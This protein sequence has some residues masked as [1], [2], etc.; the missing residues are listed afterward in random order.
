MIK[1]KKIFL[2]S[3]VA[4]CVAMPAFA[5][6]SHTGTFPSGGL[7][8]ADYTYTNAA[9]STNMDGVYE[10]TVNANAQYTT[11][12]YTVTA[13]HYLPADSEDPNTPC[14]AGNFCPGL[15]N[16]VQYSAT[17]N[18]GLETCPSGYGNSAEGA[19]ANTDCYRTCAIANNGTTF[20][21]IA[22][23]TAVS[24]NDYYNTTATDTCEPTACEN[25]WHVKPGTPDLT[26][27]IGVTE[28]GTGY[29]LNN[30]TGDDY[31]TN[32]MSNTIIANDPMAFAV[33]YGNGKGVIKG[34]GRCSKTGVTT[35]WYY[36]Q[37]YTFAADHFVNNLTNETDP[38]TGGQYCYCQL[39]SYTA[40]GSN[41]SIALSAPWVFRD[42]NDDA[43]DCVIDCAHRCASGLRRDD[44]DALAYRAAVFGSLGAP[45]PAMCEANTITINWGDTDAA[46]VT[47]NNAGTA[48]YGS[49]I[50]TPVKAQTKKGKTFTGWLFS[51]PTQQSGN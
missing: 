12:N 6:P 38:E 42:D 35:P 40:S 3:A 28:A 19:S 50:R 41:T 33:D 31:D 37:G 22:H 30:Y 15:Q 32:G 34:H 51:K 39:D 29:T 17:N 48:T 10:G 8:Q 20:T 26:T 24:G 11:N 7:M 5:E 47:A 46:D 13:G 27:T 4:M 49:D 25:G 18:Q 45:G 2:T 23:A 21:N 9:T 44:P 14:T 1:N 16:T 43:G 36:T